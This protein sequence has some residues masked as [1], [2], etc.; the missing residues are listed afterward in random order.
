MNRGNMRTVLRD[1]IGDLN[2]VNWT[3]PELDQQLNLSAQ[4]VS[5]K[6]GRIENTRRNRKTLS[7]SADGTTTEFP[8]YGV[9]DLSALLW[10]TEEP[11]SNNYTVYETRWVDEVEIPELKRR[12]PY[13]VDDDNR[14]LYTIT[15]EPNTV[16]VVTAASTSFTITFGGVTSGAIDNSGNAITAANVLAALEAMS[17]V[18]AGDFTVTGDTGGPWTITAAGNLKNLGVPTP[19]VSAG[20]ITYYDFKLK[21][22]KQITKDFTAEYLITTPEIPTG[23]EYDGYTYAII[24]YQHHELVIQHSVF[25]LIGHKD[26][27]TANFAT[28]WMRE[29]QQTATEELSRRPQPI[30]IPERVY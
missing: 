28:A 19:T 26:S 11:D 20:T 12:Y 18:T 30:E 16:W 9:D 24:P 5:N 22:L 25:V 21:L 10:I 14:I 15:H 4:Y 3:D 29:L 2:S 27:S 17:N 6:I 13:G 23:S 8:L 1:R 7:I